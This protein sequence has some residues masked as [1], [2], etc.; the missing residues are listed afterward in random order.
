MVQTFLYKTSDCAGLCVCVSFTKSQIQF[1]KSK[2]NFHLTQTHSAASVIFLLFTTLIQ[3]C[4]HFRC[5]FNFCVLMLARRM[6]VG[7]SSLTVASE[8]NH[9][10]HR[11]SSIFHLNAIFRSSHIQHEPFWHQILSLPVHWI[12]IKNSHIRLITPNWIKRI[13]RECSSN[14]FYKTLF[15]M[16]LLTTRMYI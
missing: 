3:F 7:A 14:G 4:F 10:Y 15:T 8:P 1:H 12:A 6:N 9:H 16:C 5:R 11:P 2:S 13:T